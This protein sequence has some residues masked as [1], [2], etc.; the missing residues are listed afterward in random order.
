MTAI[1]A[2]PDDS[3]GICLAVQAAKDAGIPF[4][5]IDR[6]PSGCVIDM[7]VLSDNYLAGKQSAEATVAF[8]TERYGAP[9]GKVLEIT[10]NLRRTWRSCAA[11][12]STM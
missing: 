7:T 12:G 8:L 11:A 6:S 5:T 3:A 4:Y 9:K 1:V 10:G 2:V